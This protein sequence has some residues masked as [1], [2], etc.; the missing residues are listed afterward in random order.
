MQRYA[1]ESVKQ[2]VVAYDLGPDFIRVQFSDASLYLYTYESAGTH[3]IE[4]MKE[5]ARSGEGLTE[6]IEQYVRRAYSCRD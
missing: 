6:Y 2:G 3:H 5:L 1:E 4:K